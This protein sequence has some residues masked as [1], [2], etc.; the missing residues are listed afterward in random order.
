MNIIV[1]SVSTGDET[2]PP[3]IS[4]LIDEDDLYSP[5]FEDE[6]ATGS[7]SN[8]SPLPEFL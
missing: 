2:L 5:L 3:R 8:Y 1:N 6:I 4:S 7:I